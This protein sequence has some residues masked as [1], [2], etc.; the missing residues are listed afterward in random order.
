MPA[1][2]VE[3]KSVKLGEIKLSGQEVRKLSQDKIKALDEVKEKL[4]EAKEQAQRYGKVL[5]KKYGSAL[6][7]RKYVVVAVGFDRL[8]WEE[9]VDK[10]TTKQEKT[11]NDTLACRNSAK[12]G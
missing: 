1:W 6:R 12:E 10:Q 9:V 4:K 11:A 3:F 2:R 7:L 8:V 5:E